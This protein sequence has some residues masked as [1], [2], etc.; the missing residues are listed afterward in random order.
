M[1]ERA[2]PLRVVGGS[3]IYFAAKLLIL[4]ASMSDQS[5]T[6]LPG[7]APAAVPAKPVAKAGG[8]LINITY[9]IVAVIFILISLARIYAF[10]FPSLPDCDGSVARETLSSIL[11]GQSLEATSYD[12][13]K[14]ITKSKDELT[15]SANVKIADGSL[16]Q[17]AYRVFWK[18]KDPYIELTQSDIDSPPK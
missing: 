8:R 9:M 6:E 14:T 10:F 4:E 18:D 12:G 2:S 5:G 15:C 7:S 3:F 1:L 16:L 11:K 13:M 17:I